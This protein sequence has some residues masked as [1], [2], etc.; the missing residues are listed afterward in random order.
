MKNAAIAAAVVV[1]GLAGAVAYVAYDQLKS[2]TAQTSTP[3]PAAAAP[4]TQLVETLPQFQLADRAG[5]MRSLQDW[6]D[7]A[8]IVNFWATWCAPC[9]REIPLLQQLQRDHAGEGFQV[10]GIAVDFRDKVLAYADEM[11]ID[12]PLLIGEQEALDAA[13]AFGVTTVGLPFTVFSDRQGRIVTAHLGELT[14]AEADLILDA[15]RRVD[16][17]E[18][19]P[20]DARIAL[21]AALAALPEPESADE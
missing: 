18:T 14:A 3:A 6:P 10:I 13:A 21:E 17:G 19:S 5:E 11:Q 8:L 4:A 15:V 9:R 1:A 20:T 16:A 12:Y 2:R 7:Q